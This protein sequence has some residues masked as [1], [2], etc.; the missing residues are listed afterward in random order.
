MRREENGSVKDSDTLQNKY[1][2]SYKISLKWC[3]LFK[4]ENKWNYYMKEKQNNYL[5]EN[6]DEI[7]VH[8]KN[9]ATAFNGVKKE[10]LKAKVCLIMITSVYSWIS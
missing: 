10:E 3:E 7:Y 5:N 4:G 6:N 9:S 2:K 8:Y 1:N